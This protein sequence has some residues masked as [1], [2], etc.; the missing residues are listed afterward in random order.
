MSQG[1]GLMDASVQ[2]EEKKSQFPF[3]CLFVLFKPPTDLMM[4]T[5]SG[6]GD[7]FTQSTESNANHFQKHP[8]TPRNSIFPAE[9]PLAQSG[10]HLKSTITALKE[11][12][13][14]H[15]DMRRKITD[16]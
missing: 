2:A 5:C 8:H 15:I 9:H 3:L 11:N 14:G 7:L 4:P 13:A 6:E 12:V 16:D 10:G 1:I